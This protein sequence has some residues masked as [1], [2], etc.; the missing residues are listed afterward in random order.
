MTVIPRFLSLALLLIALSPYLQAENPTSPLDEREDFEAFQ[1]LLDQIDAPSL[2]EA[3]HSFSPKKYKHGAF[4]E[5]R[6]AVKVIHKEEPSLATSIINVAQRQN[7]EIVELVRRQAGDISNGT[8]PTT[9][10]VGGPQSTTRVTPVPPVAQPST[11]SSAAPGPATTAVSSIPASPETSTNAVP[12]GT[13]TNATPSTTPAPASS[14][15]S[16]QAPTVT[17]PSVSLTAGEII[18][19]TN[20]V[21]LTIIST[22]GG[23]ASTISP[24]G[25][26]TSAKT[27]NTDVATSVQV[28]TSTL[29]NGSQSLVTAVTVVGASSHSAETPSGTAGVGP[30]GTS[31]S[32]GLQTGEAIMTRGWGK[33]MVLVVG[34]AVAFV[35]MM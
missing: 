22:V 30:S 15:P 32:P 10:P 5:D 19:T 17:S 1:K 3:L 9:T 26:K 29:P 24:T 12:L 33:E 7:A 18:T 16:S 14:Q 27:Q 11:P 35:G 20:S 28:Q 25:S 8:I 21:G 34:G 4:Q 6:T 23:G 31:A 13:S 2:H